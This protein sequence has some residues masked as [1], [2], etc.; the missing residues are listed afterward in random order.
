MQQDPYPALGAAAS[1]R[2]RKGETTKKEQLHS[3]ADKTISAESH[4]KGSH[5]KGSMSCQSHRRARER[6]KDKD[7]AISTAGEDS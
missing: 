1:R 5:S 2:H 7:G 6:G 4:S 3:N